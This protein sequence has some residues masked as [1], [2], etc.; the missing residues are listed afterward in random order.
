[1]ELFSPTFPKYFPSLIRNFCGPFPPWAVR[2][3]L[4]GFNNLN[5]SA[6]EMHRQFLLKAF[7][8]KLKTFLETLQGMA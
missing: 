4:V 3:N 1:M 6:S 8:V 7:V 5:S 2:F